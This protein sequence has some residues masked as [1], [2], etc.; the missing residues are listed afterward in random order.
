MEFEPFSKGSGLYRKYLNKAEVGSVA[1][2]RTLLA[3]M[4]G[5]EVGGSRDREKL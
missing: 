3:V 1:S 5:L 4:V 2:E